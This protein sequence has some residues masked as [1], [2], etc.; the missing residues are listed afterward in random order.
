M[1]VC[2]GSTITAAMVCA[3]LCILLLQFH[4]LFK[5][6]LFGSNPRL[7]VLEDLNILLYRKDLLFFVFDVLLNVFPHC[8]KRMIILLNEMDLKQVILL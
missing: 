1:L 6:L 4:V 5:E 3:T 2:S 7:L 8:L